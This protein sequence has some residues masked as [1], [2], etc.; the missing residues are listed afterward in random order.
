MIFVYIKQSNYFFFAP[1]AWGISVYKHDIVPNDTI[2]TITK[3]D[4]DIPNVDKYIDEFDKLPT[5]I[6]PIKTGNHSTIID[7]HIGM[8]FFIKIYNSCKNDS[9]T[10]NVV[11]LLSYSIVVISPSSAR[12]LIEFEFVDNKGSNSLVAMD[13]EV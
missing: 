4:R 9:D 3:N 8:L 2:N 10:T 13:W 5:N 6:K 12:S 1:I 11:S 7:K